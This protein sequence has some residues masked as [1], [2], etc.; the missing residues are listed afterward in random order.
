MVPGSARKVLAAAQ[1][2]GAPIARILVTHAHGDHVGSLDALA[3]ALPGA[4]VLSSAREARLLR[5]DRALEPG[6]PQDKLRGGYPRVSTV[7]GRLLEHGDRVGSLEAIAT[8][9]HT[10]GHLAFLD[11]RDGTLLCGDIF[12]TIGGVETT[13][14]TPWRFPLAAMATWSRELTLDSARRLRALE[15]ERLAPGHGRIVEAP[16]ADMDAAIA[17]AA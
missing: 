6:E 5:K 1:R 17:K 12:T 10:P 3:A 9:G 8:P 14:R 7:P 16:L 4:E 11:T 15:P 13:A 2:L